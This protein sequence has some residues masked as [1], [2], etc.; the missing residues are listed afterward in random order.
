MTNRPL[1][2][3]VQ[4]DKTLPFPTIDLKMQNTGAAAACMWR[5]MIDVIEYKEDN[6]P[7]FSFALDVNYPT[8]EQVYDE[9]GS[10]V[11]GTIFQNNGTLVLTSLNTG[12]GPAF[13]VCVS[14]DKSVLNEVFDQ[15]F[16]S[17]VSSVVES[18]QTGP[19]FRFAPSDIELISFATSLERQTRT[20][21]DLSLAALDRLKSDPI[22]QFP[23]LASL[24]GPDSASLIRR[25][26]NHVRLNQFDSSEFREFLSSKVAPS[27]LT[28]IKV[29]GEDPANIEELGEDPANIKELWDDVRAC[30]NGNNRK[31]AALERKIATL[32]KRGDSRKIYIVEIPLKW[33]AKTEF[34]TDVEG[35]QAVIPTVPLFLTPNG[36]LEEHYLACQ[37]MMISFVE[38]VLIDNISNK[39]T[40]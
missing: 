27:I 23:E 6:S 5:L 19:T 33:S 31:I 26:V 4:I 35:G 28:N 13:D 40:K 25:I 1:G 39:S 17:A 10:I 32:T 9:S 14:V 7:W 16:A 20:K 8:P 34:G 11:P 24:L 36:F 12:W 37:P 21:I 29:L 3:L 18:G 38:C 15:R 30:I 22:F 2:N